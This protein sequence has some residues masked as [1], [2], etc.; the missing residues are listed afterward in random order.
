LSYSVKEENGLII[1]GQVGKDVHI[2]QLNKVT[3]RVIT[4]LQLF[5]STFF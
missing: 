4:G 2:K 1:C 3:H 5:L